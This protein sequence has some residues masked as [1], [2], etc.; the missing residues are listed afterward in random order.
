MSDQR[1]EK[2]DSFSFF[3]NKECD[4]HPCHPSVKGKFNCLFC[5]CPMYYAVC[6]GEPEYIQINGMM[7]KDC[8]GCDYPHRPEN[9]STI[10]D[11]LT[12][13]LRECA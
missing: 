13:M 9:Y 11:Y 5:F 1:E 10:V 7:V 3:E 8:S 12:L 4:Y 6:I 2:K